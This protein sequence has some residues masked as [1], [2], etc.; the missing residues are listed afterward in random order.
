M[1]GIFSIALVGYSVVNPIE[2]TISLKRLDKLSP[3]LQ[4]AQRYR[5]P[6]AAA[7]ISKENIM[8]QRYF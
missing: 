2:V 8:L 3:D 6:F 4:R 7:R 1:S 5:I